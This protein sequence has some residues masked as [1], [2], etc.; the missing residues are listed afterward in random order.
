MPTGVVVF[1]DG[2]VFDPSVFGAGAR[3]DELPNAAAVAVV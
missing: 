3:G 2:V 1:D